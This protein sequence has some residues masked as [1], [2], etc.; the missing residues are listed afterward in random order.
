MLNEPIYTVSEINR[1]AKDLL[2]Q[3]LG[4]FWIEGEI[5]NL[6]LAPSGHAYFT[7]KDEYAEIS[8]VR[9]RPRTGGLSAMAAPADGDHVVA[10]G[11]LSIYEPR[12]RYQFIASMIQAAGQ[13]LLQLAFERLKSKL[14]SEGLFDAKHKQPLPPIPR[15]VAVITS[16]SGAAIRDIASVVERRFPLI[17]LLLFPSSVQGESAAQELIEAIRRV[18]RYH[19]ESEPFDALIIG[20]GGGSAED[21]AV[22]NDEGLARALFACPIPVIAAVGHEV[23]FTI[24]DFVADV[25]APTPSAAAELIAPDGAEMLSRILHCSGRIG[26]ATTSAFRS[27]QGDLTHAVRRSVLRLPGDR[28]RRL[29]QQL[30]LSIASLSYRVG[31][32]LSLRSRRLERVSEIIRFSDP[33]LPLLRGYSMTYAEGEA[34]PLRDISGVSSGARL[35]TRLANGE[36]LSIV[37]EVNKAVERKRRSGAEET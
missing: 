10:F 15:R 26:R 16:S 21:L 29:S 5:S 28:V 3:Q 1:K 36:I 12:G 11:R 27:R 19:A 20:R 8:A 22:F 25:R 13:G 4:G 30:D 7:L 14:E 24:T 18:T 35:R 37:E 34:T 31:G 17:E 2:E 33:W 6:K 32:A 23:D 9:F